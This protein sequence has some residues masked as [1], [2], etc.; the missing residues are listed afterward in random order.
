M[1]RGERPNGLQGKRA[2]NTRRLPGSSFAVAPISG[3]R[4]MPSIVELTASYSS[5]KRPVNPTPWLGAA[6]IDM[7]EDELYIAVPGK[8]LPR[9]AEANAK[10]SEYHRGR[11]HALATE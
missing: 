10:F 2:T 9:I 7:G 5:G 8:D 3:C 4:S 1:P 11:R 6:A